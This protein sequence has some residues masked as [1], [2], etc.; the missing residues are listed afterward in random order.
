MEQAVCLEIDR[1]AQLESFVINL[2]RG[3]VDR[4]VIRIGTVGRL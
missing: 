3:F 4:N 1:S 2:D